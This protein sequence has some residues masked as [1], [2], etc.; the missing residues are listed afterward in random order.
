MLRQSSGNQ[1][2][3]F[4]YVGMIGGT[5]RD[6]A[7]SL[8]LTPWIG[9]RDQL[10]ADFARSTVAERDHLPELPSCVDVHQRKWDRTRM[11]SLLCEAQHHRRVFAD[12]VKHHR[13]GGGSRD[14]ADNFDRLGL[15]L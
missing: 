4:H 1:C 14:F 6:R 13:L 3:G 5:V 8:S 9:I 2:F 12:R 11:E 15:K 10:K 7:D